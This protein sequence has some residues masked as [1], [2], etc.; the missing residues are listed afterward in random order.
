MSSLSVG[1]V[2]V[3]A[4]EAADGRVLVEGTDQGDQVG[5]CHVGVA[6]QDLAYQ[7]LE[8]YGGE[9]GSYQQGEHGRGG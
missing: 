8:I 4:E 3:A 1:Q 6:D 9:T 7:N 5:F 2:T